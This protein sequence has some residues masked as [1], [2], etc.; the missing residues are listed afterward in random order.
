[1]KSSSYLHEIYLGNEYHEFHPLDRNSSREKAMREVF[2]CF[3]YFFSYVC[4]NN[5]LSDWVVFLISTAEIR[6]VVVP[7]LNVQ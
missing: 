5:H 3:F 4:P 7:K 2:N 6:I 1:M